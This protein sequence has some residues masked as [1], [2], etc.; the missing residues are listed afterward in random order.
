MNAERPRDPVA[1]FEL[2]LDAD[3]SAAFLATLMALDEFLALFTIVPVT[4]E[5]SRV[6]GH[7]CPRCQHASG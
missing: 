5:I 6:A 4:E 2:T 3:R 1:W 7:R